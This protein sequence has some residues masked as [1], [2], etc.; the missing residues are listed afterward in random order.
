MNNG[1][2]ANSFSLKKLQGFFAEQTLP[3]IEIA[4]RVLRYRTRRDLLS[5]G[6]GAV[7]AAGGAGFLLS[8][9]PL[10]RPVCMAGGSGCLTKLF[11]STM[12]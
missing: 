9:N 4:P 11:V 12:T 6:A 2:K 1:H 8:Q 5:V 10:S 3:A 7:A